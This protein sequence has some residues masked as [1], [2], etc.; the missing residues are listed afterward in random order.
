M[1]KHA[2]PVAK[3]GKKC[4]C[5]GPHVS[6]VPNFFKTRLIGE[7]GARVGPDRGWSLHKG[8]G[9]VGVTRAFGARW[10][11]SPRSSRAAAA[12]AAARRG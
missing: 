1:A 11:V 9:S 7:A 6:P 2:R 3:Y 8:S 5:H 12:A 4:V 10:F